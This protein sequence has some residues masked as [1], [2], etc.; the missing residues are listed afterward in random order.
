MVMKI[1]CN[2]LVSISEVKGSSQSERQCIRQDYRRSATSVTAPPPNTNNASASKRCYHIC[3]LSTSIC[4]GLILLLVQF[5][6]P[7]P[8][9]RGR[10]FKCYYQSQHLTSSVTTITMKITI[11]TSFL[12]LNL[13]LSS[14]T[15][16]SLYY[17]QW[18]VHQDCC[19]SRHS[20]NDT[21]IA[22]T[23]FQFVDLTNG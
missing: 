21:I 18:C 3:V 19:Q 20:H 22:N 7:I 15:S 8:H 4:A 1:S 5:H 23:L 6:L 11:T 9:H 10:H 17:E 16:P 14:S 13:N 12:N 2:I